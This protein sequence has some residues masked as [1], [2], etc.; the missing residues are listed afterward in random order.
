MNVAGLAYKLEHSPAAIL[1]YR[2]VDSIS[3]LPT[4][5]GLVPP[6]N[7]MAGKNEDAIK[8]KEA[9]MSKKIEQ[10]NIRRKRAAMAAR[11]L[12]AILNIPISIAVEETLAA[13]LGELRRHIE[14]GGSPATFRAGLIA[15]AREEES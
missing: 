6:I 3:T 14:M 10:I 15:D 7:P 9:I 8:W 12:A 4:I 5:S 2:N 11:E 13:A 1:V